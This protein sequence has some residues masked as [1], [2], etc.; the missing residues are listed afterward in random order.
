MRL[1]T[2]LLPVTFL[3]TL[4]LTLA[5]P[6]NP[7][8]SPIPSSALL[9]L[10]PHQSCLDTCGSVCYYS[11]TVAAAQSR[12]YSLFSSGDDI[13]SYPHIY[14]NWEGLDFP[15]SG[16]YYEYPILRTF[17]VYTGGDPGPDRVIFNS[18]NQYAGLITHQGAS[19]NAFED[20]V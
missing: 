15:I 6:L 19:G 20:C 13:N 9:H 11:N 14:N 4:T 8:T 17:R 3:S 2:I 7:D 16:P 12:G 10:I 1:S 18:R 5:L